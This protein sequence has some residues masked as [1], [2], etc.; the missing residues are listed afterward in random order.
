MKKKQPTPEQFEG[1]ARGV[2][3]LLLIYILLAPILI[4]ELARALSDAGMP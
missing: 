3:A 4:P 2:F 1:I